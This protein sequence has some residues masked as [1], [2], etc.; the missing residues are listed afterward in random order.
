MRGPIDN[1]LLLAQSPSTEVPGSVGGRIDTSPSHCIRCSG[2]ARRVWPRTPGS[3]STYSSSPGQIRVGL[4]STESMRSPMPGF[5]VELVAH[6]PW[7]LRISNPYHAWPT[8]EVAMTT[9]TWHQGGEL[10]L[11][12]GHGFR[13]WYL[14]L[15]LWTRGR[16]ATRELS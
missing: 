5:R 15:V 2:R 10:A 7:Y 6:H 3:G 4:L 12:S 11:S 16:R 14:A 8:S 13:T 1:K 9:T